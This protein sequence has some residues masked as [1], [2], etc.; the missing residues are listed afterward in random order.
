MRST[1]FVVG[2]DEGISRLFLPG[3]AWERTR[4][5]DRIFTRD[6]YRLRF[7]VRGAHEDVLSTTTLL[8]LKGDVKYIRPLGERM[9]F[10][11][12]AGA[13]RTYT[14]EFHELPATLRF[15]AGGDQS[16]RGYDY[17]SLGPR[18]AE[19]HVSGGE[20]TVVGSTELE[21]MFLKSWGV[22]AFFDA[23]NAFST[24][25]S[26]TFEK[27]T[28]AGLRWLSPVGLIRVDG[29][30][31]VGTPNMVRLHIGIGPDL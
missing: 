24:S 13:G 12:R 18:D 7:I 15:F 10:I 4:A 25:S 17:E 9:R 14:D 1:Y 8:Q 16:V 2:V 30:Y 21:L 22:A 19:G 29:A 5:D 20:I 27:G 3:L 31:A 6:G 11:A 26:W 23:G 28:G